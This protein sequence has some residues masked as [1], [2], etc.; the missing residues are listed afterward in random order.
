MTIA[1]NV[2]RV[3]VLALLVTACNQEFNTVGVDLIATD[4][5]DT[6]VREFPVFVS[7]NNLE[8]VQSDQLGVVHFGSYNF[9]NFGR[10]KANITSQLSI[11]TDPRFGIY[12]QE[13]EETGDEDNINVINENER[14]TS[15]FLE[16]PFLVNQNDRDGDGV[17]DALDIDPD[18]NQSDTDGDGVIDLLESQGG[19]NPFDAD[20][21]GDGI[22]DNEDTDSSG[23]DAGENYYEIDSIFGNRSSRFNLKVTE[24]TYHF[25]TLDPNNNF[26]TPTGYFS[27]RD[28]YEE[29]F[30]GRSL[31]DGPF[32]LDFDEISFNY[33]EDDPETPD[34]DETTQVETRLSPRL[35]IPLD[36]SYFQEKILDAEGSDALANDN[37][38]KNH[39]KGINIRMENPAEDLYMLL[40]LSGAIIRLNYE[41]DVNQDQDT[42]D[43]SDDVIETA[44]QTYFISPNGIQINHL[45]NEQ[46]TLNSNPQERLMLNGG[47]G[48]LGQIKLFDQDDTTTNLADFR[49][50]N[51]LINEANLVFYV[52]PTI[53]ENWSEGDLIAD[54]LYLYRLEDNSPLA[55]YY[56]DPTS[57]A[58]NLLNKTIHS[59]ILE[60]QDGIPYRYKFRI[61]EHVSNLIRSENEDLAENVELGLVVTANINAVFVKN[62]KLSEDQDIFY[63]LAALQNPLGTLLV[64]PNPPQ[65]LLDKQLK[66]EVVYTDFNN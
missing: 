16:I 23:Y 17:I 60:Y 6:E 1:K 7:V 35:R 45:E 37:N 9:T 65:E 46:V 36:T 50:S 22:T 24:L 21:D 59:G 51:I 13:Q 52:D 30:T 64:G 11:A 12:T 48:N 29:G 66:L 47:L 42:E 43:T 2:F 55:D 19:T 33:T 57:G 15:V 25:N 5:F 39:I 40:N 54:R 18:D 14:I 32:Q 61:T 41:Y 58:N 56:S 44:L 26:E 31:Y 38:F 34:I 49:S 28:F 63:P 20:S 62:A 27:G 4:Q 8:D 3:G 53:T 10:K